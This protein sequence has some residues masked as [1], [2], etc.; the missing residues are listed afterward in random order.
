VRPRFFIGCAGLAAAALCWNGF[1][2]SQPSAE[3][4]PVADSERVRL[5]MQ[6]ANSC[7]AAAC[8]NADALSGVRGRE[9]A[10]AVQRDP[11]DPEQRAKDKHAQAYEVLF[12]ERSRAMEQRLRGLASPQDARPEANALCLRCHVH[13]DFEKQASREIDGVRQF[14]REDGV[15][16]E[17]CHGPAQRWLAE[18]FR[19]GW[20]ELSAAE[21]AGQGMTDTR[22]LHG[23]VR[24]CVAC[25]VGAPGMEVNHDLI[26]AGHPRLQFEFS[27]Y[28]FFLHKHWDQARDRAVPDFEMRG[29][30]L[31]QLASAQAALRLLAARAEASE[32]RA[33]PWPEF[34]EYACFACHHDLKAKSWR[35][36][37][38]LAQ[39]RAAKAPRQPLLAWDD[40]YYAQLPE[41]VAAL[42]GTTEEKLKGHL[43]A[44]RQQMEA[45]R[46]NRQE[47]AKLATA[48]A[49]LVEQELRRGEQTVPNVERIVA[50]GKEQNGESWSESA[51][52][53]LAL[54][55]LSRARPGLGMLLGGPGLRE[56]RAL[57]RFP[58]G[59]DSPRDYDA[60]KIRAQF[61]ALP[62][63]ASK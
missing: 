11:H 29:W 14:R 36:E 60:E 1:S 15:G 16:C 8:H 54:S 27:S 17:T 30:A 5:Q 18:H 35:Q 37:R 57:L 22:S 24:L 33:A 2:F 28:H 20:T 45:P 13:P 52:S 53:Y 49:G 3:K 12:G 41:A 59:Y 23:R 19:A 61:Q 34:A 55:A 26:A 7:A 42:Q 32:H 40:W 63:G 47:I 44:L 10:L 25:H 62:R 58:D 31:G 6:G 51:Q 21:R 50:R 9:F 46:P 38:D 39:A 48:A 4:A 56:L 43:T